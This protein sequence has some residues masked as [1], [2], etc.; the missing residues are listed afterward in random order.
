MTDAP[1]H[2]ESHTLWKPVTA[3]LVGTALLVAFGVSFVIFDFGQGSPMQ[4]W[5]P[6]APGRRLLTGFL[7]GTTGALIALSPLGRLSGAH[8]NPVVSVAFWMMGKLRARHALANVAAQCL[9]GLLGALPL[10]WWGAMGRSVQFGATL[11]SPAFGPGLAVAGEV[12]TTFI[13]VALLL[14]FV[15][16]ARLRRFTPAL[17][18]VLYAVMVWLEA[19]ISGTSTNPARSLGPMVMA[20]RW[21]GWW[22]YWLGPAA[23]MAL[24]VALHRTP[25]MRRFEIEI[26]KLYHF[27]HDPEGWFS[28]ATPAAFGDLTQGA[29]S[30]HG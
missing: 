10:L 18:P 3:E 16:H 8:I 26:A 6:S 17:F 14:A 27:D 29:P 11:P 23:G 4:G 15:G 7:F 21:D 30:R 2:A 22:I 25:W 20:L 5:I 28:Q 12:A 19:P 24:A 13:M 9:G 1:A